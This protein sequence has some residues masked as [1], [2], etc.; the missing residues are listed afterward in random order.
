MRST[1][2][3]NYKEK[4]IGSMLKLAVCRKTVE[5]IFFTSSRGNL[6]QKTVKEILG[7]A[8]V[9]VLLCSDTVLVFV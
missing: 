3:K 1:Q 2:H 5:I 7:I 4:V 9:P 6:L 8:I